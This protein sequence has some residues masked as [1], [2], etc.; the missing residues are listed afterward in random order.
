MF[1]DKFLFLPLLQEVLGVDEVLP[2]RRRLPPEICAGGV[3]LVQL[4]TIIV[5]ARDEKRHPEWTNATS[6][7][8]LLHHSRRIPYQLPHGLDLLRVHTHQ[9]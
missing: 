3:H 5:V 9:G 6:L 8:V 2:D 4:G 7:S 1:S